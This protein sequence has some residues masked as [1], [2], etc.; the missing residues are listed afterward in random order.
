M[1]QVYGNFGIGVVVRT[2]ENL[3]LPPDFLDIDVGSCV[4][5]QTTNEQ[6][7]LFNN[8]NNVGTNEVVVY[9]VR[10]TNPPLNGCAAFPANRPGAIV[11]RTASE[12]TL[13]HE[14]GHVLGL[15]HVDAS[16]NWFT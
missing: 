13:A 12:W 6:N 15:P 7:Q 10:A 2:I 4:R 5:G 3:N 8:R 14:V 1:R 9:M 16:P 11:V